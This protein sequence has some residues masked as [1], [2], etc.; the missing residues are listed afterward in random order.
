[1]QI[2]NKLFKLKKV[3]IYFIS[4]VL[5]IIIFSTTYLHAN[6]FKISDIEI[7]SPFELD[8]N[9]DKV[10]DDGFRDSFYNLIFMI[11]TSGDRGKIEKISLKQI[12]G[13]IDSFTISDEKFINDEYSAKLEVTFNKK[14]ILIF[15]EKK[16]IFP[17]IPV[18]NKVLLIPI[19]VDLETDRNLFFY[20]KYLL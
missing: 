2:I 19:L 18:K 15:L 14:N 3:Y 5:F 13:M 11:T 7:S 4:L 20:K 6:A 12:K 10:I 17:S 1:M 16:N 8:F 9:K